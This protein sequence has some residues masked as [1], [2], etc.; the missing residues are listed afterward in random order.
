MSDFCYSPHTKKLDDELVEI[1]REAE[2]KRA[3]LT[4]AV[5]VQAPATGGLERF[6]DGDI[7][8]ADIV[9]IKLAAA[10]ADAASCLKTKV[11]EDAARTKI[12]EMMARKGE[13]ISKFIDAAATA[14]KGD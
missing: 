10:A 11:D 9:G 14:L 5:P 3:E 6:V 8:G 12:R 13:K 1:C 4:M 7:S 2:Q